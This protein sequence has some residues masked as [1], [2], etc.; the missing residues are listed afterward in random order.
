MTS[1]NGVFYP[2]GHVFALFPTQEAAQQTAA[3]LQDAGHQ[4]SLA[5]AAPEDIRREVTRTVDDGDIG[6]PSV[7][8]DNDIVRRID[9]LAQRGCHGV[10]IE[11]TN[12]DA[13]ENVQAML[14]RR[15]ATAAFYYRTF[16][17]EELAEQPPNPQPNDGTVWMGTHAPSADPPR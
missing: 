14:T 5:Y 17:I 13:I 8:A 10:L 16:I 7:G 4:G 9:D 3:A 11:V 1:M 15:Q 6:M 12:R 2:T